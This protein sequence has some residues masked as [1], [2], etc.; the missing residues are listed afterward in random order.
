MSQVGAAA[1]YA[2]VVSRLDLDLIDIA[3]APLPISPH[4]VEEVLGLSKLEACAG[5]IAGARKGYFSY[6]Y[7]VESGEE[8]ISFDPVC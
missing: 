6:V 5:A 4:I 8:I 3:F 1:L 2:F 7:E